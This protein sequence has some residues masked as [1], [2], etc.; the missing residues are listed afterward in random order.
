LTSVVLY[1]VAIYLY[2]RSNALST[3]QS[4]KEW[5]SQKEIAEMLGVNVRKLY[6]KVSILRHAGVI[7]TLPDPHDDRAILVHS[8]A[9]DSL[10]RALRLAEGKH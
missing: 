3:L 7:Q 1:A 8:S 9:L 6:P 2:Y 10:K 4:Q 5:L